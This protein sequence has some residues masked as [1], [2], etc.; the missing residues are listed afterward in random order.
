MP[1]WLDP[2]AES[3]QYSKWF[4]MFCHYLVLCFTIAWTL[5]VGDLIMRQVM[6]THNAFG[7]PP[8]DPDFAWHLAGPMS[9]RNHMN[10]T[11]NDPASPTYGLWIP[12]PEYRDICIRTMGSPMVACSY[13][14]Y[15]ENPSF[16]KFFYAMYIEDFA[17]VSRSV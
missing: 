15:Q 14:M 3:W 16:M 6:Y 7:D 13:F 12:P 5:D 8:D 9:L 4:S 2:T 10:H 1:S 17:V 11:D